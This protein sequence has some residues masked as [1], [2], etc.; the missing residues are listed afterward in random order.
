GRRPVFTVS[1]IFLII[2][3]IG[4]ALSINIGMLIGFRVTMAI[5][6]AASNALGA[7]I[8]IDVF[9]DH[10]KG[11]ALS[12]YASV[13]SYCAAIAPLLGGAMAQ[14]FGW[15]SIFWLF[16]IS[17]GLL[18][19]II[20]FFLPETNHYALQKQI[21]QE[22][23]DDAV[24]AEIS[25]SSKKKSWEKMINP[26]SSLKLLRFPNMLLCCL[27]LGVMYVSTQYHFSSTMV[28]LFYLAGIAGNTAGTYLGG[29]VSD[30][31]Y[32]HRV[33]KAKEE[34]KQV[35]PEMR[36]SQSVLFVAAF[37]TAAL[38]SAY[39]WFVQ[40][41]VHFSAGIVCQGLGKSSISFLD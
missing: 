37:S 3:N 12:W 24:D 17:H 18:G 39:G 1:N 23:I 10:E 4:S 9:E 31:I 14:Y 16:V 6:S 15:R 34:D 19:L 36:L 13:L 21:D 2:G 26:F 40:K 30:R 33:G 35:Y 38:F 11:K 8:I 29:L 28:G 22:Q 7:G 20:L 32:M 27:Y 25:T 5:G 41:D